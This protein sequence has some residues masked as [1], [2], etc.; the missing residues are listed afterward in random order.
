MYCPAPYLEIV[1]WEKVPPIPKSFLPH[2]CCP[3][4]TPHVPA[5]MSGYVRPNVGYSGQLDG[6]PNVPNM[7]PGQEEE[8]GSECDFDVSG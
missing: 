5:G 2:I 8:G 3:S 1:V 7:L 6:M 4:H